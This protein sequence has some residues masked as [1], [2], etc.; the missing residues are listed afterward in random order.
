MDIRPATPADQDA[1]WRIL[2]PVIRGGETYALLRDMSR[3]DALA[4]WTA[5]EKHCFVAETD[6]RVLGTY[7]LRANQA[8]PGDHVCNC[9]YVTDEAARGKGIARRMCEHS[10]GIARGLGFRAMQFNSVV[11]T[12]EGAVA[13]WQRLGF[14]IVGTLPGAFRHPTEGDVDAYVMYRKL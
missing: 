5:P 3:A 4:Y 8:G 7:Y 12:N 13:L 11:S 9:G 2:E 1:I 10:F 14:E 6:G